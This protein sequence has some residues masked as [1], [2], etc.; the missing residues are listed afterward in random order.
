M[1]VPELPAEA[2][3]RVVLVRLDAADP[4]R[5][6]DDVDDE[7]RARELQVVH[8]EREAETRERVFVVR[9]D[10][11]RVFFRDSEDVVPELES[12]K[13][14]ASRQTKGLVTDPTRNKVVQ[15]FLKTHSEAKPA[16]EK[17]E[18]LTT[19]KSSGKLLVYPIKLE[20]H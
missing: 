6:A 4:D 11:P 1:R 19:L 5:V 16:V 18:R 8:A 15:D 14:F 7:P 3:G 13:E 20:H 17:G 10:E 12:L 9:T 2:Q